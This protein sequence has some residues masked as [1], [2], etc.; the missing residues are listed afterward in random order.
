ML[1]AVSLVRLDL[2]AAALNARSVRTE[3]SR[4]RFGAPAAGWISPRSGFGGNALAVAVTLGGVIG[5]VGTFTALMMSLSRLP[6]AMTEDG[7]L[8]KVFAKRHPKNG[9]PW[10][11]IIACAIMW[12]LFFPL[13]FEKLVIINVLLTRAVDRPR[14][15]RIHC[16]AHP[17]ARFAAA[18]SRAGRP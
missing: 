10:V 9:A 7:Y 5:A 18:I 6:L 13:G 11:A 16:T 1:G 12:T 4:K 17:R 14:V 3:D 15:R 8:P 2:R